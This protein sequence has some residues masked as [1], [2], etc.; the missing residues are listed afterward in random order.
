MRGKALAGHIDL[1]SS[2]CVHD[3]RY[4]FFQ[5]GLGS[6]KPNSEGRTSQFFVQ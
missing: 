4:C 5:P 1:T 6:F 3:A 2:S